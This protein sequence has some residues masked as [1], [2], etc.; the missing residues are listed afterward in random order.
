MLFRVGVADQDSLRLQ[1]D[2]S[3]ENPP[4][5]YVMK[6]HVFEATDF[7]CASNVVLKK[8]ATDND[9]Y[10]V[11]IQIV[12]RIFCLDDVLKY[13]GSPEDAVRQANQ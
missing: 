4:E 11:T 5:E 6:V 7:P 3:F 10:L 12:Y 9:C 2:K 13:V 1:W 8:T